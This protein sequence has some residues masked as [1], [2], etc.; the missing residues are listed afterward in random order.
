M[1][2]CGN[3][4]T[5]VP[6]GS[7]FCPNCGQKIEE[8]NQNAVEQTAEQATS[9]EQS[10][11]QG[12]YQA[13][14]Q[15]GTYQAGAQQ[16]AYQTNGQQGAYQTNGQQGA[17]QTNGQQGAYQ[18]NGYQTQPAYG[19][20]Q[21]G[22]SFFGRLKTDK[23]L[24]GICAGVLAA[25]VLIIG[26]VVWRANAAKTVDL[27]DYYTVEFSGANSAGTATV[28]V[29]SD[30]LYNA[31]TDAGGNKIITY[32]GQY[33]IMNSIDAKVT[34]D[35]KLSNGDKVTLSFTYSSAIAKKYGVKIKGKDVK[36]KVEGLKDVEEIDPFDYVT[37]TYDG[38]EPYIY[39]NVEVDSSKIKFLDNVYFSLD[40]YSGLSNGDEFTVTAEVD[41]DYALS[42]GY[43]L[44]KTE[45]KY[46][47]DSADKYITSLDDLTEGQLA[48]LQK[49]AL[50]EITA[51]MADEDYTISEPAYIGAYLLTPKSKSSYSGN[52]LYLIY[53]VSATDPDG[54]F[55]DVPVYMPIKVED[56]LAKGDGTMDYY[57]VDLDW[58]Y[59]YPND[60]WTSVYGYLDGGELYSGIVTSNVDNYTATVYGDALKAFGE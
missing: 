51:E 35:E 52:S 43:R 31:L 36:V 40:T 34:P 56:V 8:P 39:P 58:H 10:G 18:T 1:S 32:S 14:A 26:I 48:E 22:A 28:N 60:G 20:T 44:K 12:T 23:K 21:N 5:Q 37:I 29:D 13:G 46:T 45:K 25:I 50:D 2:F 6:E 53:Q 42:Q 49:E 54:D 47:V 3:C 4:G 7:E 27:S 38:V 57:S 24:Q 16:G 30:K 15:Q 55:A 41:E 19:N 59:E 9:V 33:D 11:Q 17:Y